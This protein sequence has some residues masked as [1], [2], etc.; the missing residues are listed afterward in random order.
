MAFLE[1]NN[2]DKYYDDVHAVKGIDLTIE[3]GE[4]IAFVG[5]SGSGK[6]T[7]MRM[8]AGLEDVSSGTIKLNKEDITTIAHSK[9]DL[10]MVEQTHSLYPHM[11]VEE[12]L[13]FALRLANTPEDDIHAQVIE[14][15]EQLELLPC[16]KRKPRELS[17]GQRQRVAIGRAII[18]KPKLLL[19]DEPLSNLDATLRGQT[20]VEIASLHEDLGSTTLYVTHDHVE[21][22]T[23]ADR[24]VIL[25]EG[26][27]QQVGTPE[28]IY[29]HPANR[30]VA[31]F[32]GLPQMNILPVNLN[33]LPIHYQ[34]GITPRG[35][36]QLGIRP[37]HLSVS[38]YTPDL[39]QGYVEFIEPLGSESLIHV[40]LAG[41]KKG[42]VI[43]RQH[44]RCNWQAGDVVSVAWDNSRIHFFNNDGKTLKLASSGA[45]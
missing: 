31:Q 7:L 35:S 24:V 34:R 32:I 38:E 14:T 12:N 19:L 17:G 4:F 8:I 42:P 11:T 37:E 10:A 15:A 43:V 36:S 13:S 23:L 2:L 25:N 41:D 27:I 39:L 30:F 21:A 33:V 40:N 20:R 6:S 3:Q 45:L 1:L 18:K 44:E 29:E 26:V 16:L 22:M 9:R 5:P 28:E